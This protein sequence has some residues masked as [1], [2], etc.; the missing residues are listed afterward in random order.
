M[1]CFKIDSIEYGWFEFRVGSYDIE[2]SDYLGYDIS[3]EFL[4]KLIKVLDCQSKERIYIMHEPGAELMELE[5]ADDKII[6]SIYPLDKECYDL[7]ADIEKEAENKG[8]CCYSFKY[9]KAELLDCVVTEYSLYENGN[10]RRYY[11][12]NW[13]EFPQGEY[14]ELKKIAFEINKSLS[15]LNTMVC[16]DFLKI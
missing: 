13:G 3:G 12:L 6:I 8:E 7:S 9:D 4:S 15:E 10:G 2:A 11:E 1:K 5:S 14:D 16:V